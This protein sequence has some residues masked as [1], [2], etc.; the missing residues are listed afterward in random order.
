VILS[1]LATYHHNFITHLLEAELLRRLYRI[2]EA[3]EPITAKLLGDETADL[4]ARF[5]GDTVTLD[6]HARL[7]W[8]WQPHY[9]MGLY[10]YAYSVGLAGATVVAQSID[11]EGGAAAQRWV[12][13]L[14][15]GSTLRGVDQFRMVGVDMTTPEPLR[16][17]VAYVGSLVDELEKLCA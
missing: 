10:P 16:Q 6:E 15:T 12:E 7:N 14:K 2:A 5:W 11:R 1:L 4:L 3:D 13:V 17:V 8:M 9:Y